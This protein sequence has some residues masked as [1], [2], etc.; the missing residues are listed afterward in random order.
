VSYTDPHVPRLEQGGHTL[1]T[2]PFEAAL[3][4]PCDCA[5][6]ATD[7]TSFDYSRIADLPLVVDTRNA[8]KAFKRPSIFAL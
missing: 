7:H 6:V 8:M 5:V 1:T 4:R 2:I 3:S